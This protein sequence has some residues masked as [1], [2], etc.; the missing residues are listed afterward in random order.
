M[1]F[2]RVNPVPY[3]TVDLIDADMVKELAKR[4]TKRL[5][6]SEDFKKVQQRIER[7]KIQKARK[8]IALNEKTFVAERKELGALTDIAAEAEKPEGE[9]DAVVNRNYYFNEA[10]AITLDYAQMLNKHKPGATN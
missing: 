10:L 5:A 1:A 3:K 8:R 4:S 6:T 9:E 7:Y 2:D